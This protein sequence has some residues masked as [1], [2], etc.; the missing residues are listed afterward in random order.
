MPI[1]SYSRMSFGFNMRFTAANFL[2]FFAFPWNDCTHH[3]HSVMKTWLTITTEDWYLRCIWKIVQRR[4][5]NTAWASNYY[6][7]RRLLGK[8]PL[9]IL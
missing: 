6:V 5:I 8:C 1:A 4:K 3:R 2:V 9:I 7:I